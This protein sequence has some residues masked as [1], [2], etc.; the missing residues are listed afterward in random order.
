MRRLLRR[1]VAWRSP[2]D[3]EIARELRDHLELEAESLAGAG[4]NRPGG[5]AHLAAQRRFGNVSGAGEAVHEVWH[6]AWLEQFAQDVRHGARALVRSPAYSVAIVVTL[7]MGI[8]AAAATY[9]LSNAIHTPFPRLPEDKLLWIT[10]SNPSCTPDCTELSPPAL[11]A[12][13]KRAPSMTAIG[14]TGWNAALRSGDGSE[15]VRGYQVS[16]NTFDV[17]GAP[18]ALGRTFPAGSAEQGGPGIVVLSYNFWHDRFAASRGVLDSVITLSGKAYTVSGVLDKDV[19]FPMVADVYTP[20][21]LTAAAESQFSE[22]G[23]EV[24]AR[25]APG[26]SL[27]T[28]RAETRTIGAQLAREGPPTERSWAMSA[29]PISDFHTDDVILIER[30]A[31]IAA[32]LVFLAA[33]MS[34]ANLALSRIAARRH[35]LALRTALGVRRWRL[36]RHLLTETLLLSLVAGALGVLLAQWG[37]HAI[38]EAIPADFAAFVPGW[39]RLGVHPRTLVFTVGAALSAMLAFASLPLIRATRVDLTAVLSDGGRASTGGVH[40]TRTRAI[41]IVLEVSIAVVLLTAA[42]L[43]TRSVRNMI[44]GDAGVRLDHVLVMPVTLPPSLSDTATVD[45]YRRL[46]ENL[47]IAPGVRAA[48][49]ATATP[50]SNNFSGANF[51]IPGRAPERSGEPLDAI[52][53]HVTPDYAKAAGVRIVRGRMIDAHDVAGAGRALVVNRMMADAMWPRGN[54]LGETV[55]IDSTAWI[56]VG[57]SANVHHGGL[58]EPM[59]YTFYR[60]LYQA[61]LQHSALAVWTT[62]DPAGM[63]DSVRR[64]VARTDPSVAVGGMM[65]MTAMQARHVSAFGMMAGMLAVLAVVTMTIA[66]V[67]LYGLI[68]YGVAQRTREIGVRIALGARPRDVV[69]HISGGAVRLTAVGVV[70]GVAG[71]AGFARLLSAMLY[72]VSASDPRTYIGVSVGLLLVAVTAAG[73]PSWRAS[74]VDPTIA[75]RD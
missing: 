63:R 11:I 57:V 35:E 62:G 53:Q 2:S 38:R 28:A 36:A 7:A 49:M 5:D 40:S 29:R 51:T 58:D 60:S 19:V 26:A 6:S 18:F 66:T 15:L 1:I 12:L 74:K 22:R 13:G 44:A 27:A 23:F 25:L 32:L 54:A 65:T 56:V 70:V 47:R 17:I 34:A 73:I 10:W 24:F 3:S 42:T 21:V 75:L 45:F 31:G 33:C 59:R 39:V 14:V 72:A 4:T 48:G 20:F 61:P 69:L 52:D 71:A 50:L 55:M 30:I 64:V 41:L 43:F 37:V 8:G 46:D 16:P 68:A 67:G 9:S